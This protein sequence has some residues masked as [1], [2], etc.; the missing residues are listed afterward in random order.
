L[1]ILKKDIARSLPVLLVDGGG[2]VVTGVV[3]GSVTVVT[4]KNGGALTGFTLTNK[5]TELGQ[6]LYTID[7]ADTDL[8]TEGFFA[9]LVTVTGCDQYSGIMYVSDWETNVDSILE[10][11]AEIGTAGASLTDLGGMSTGMKAEVQQEGEDALAAYDPPTRTELTTDKN[12]IIAEVD[13]NEAKIDTIDTVVDGIQTDLSNDTDGLGALKAL[14]DAIDTVVDAIKDVTDQ[15]PDAGALSDLA[16]LATRLSAVRAG[17]LDELASYN[18]PADVDTLKTY[19][20]ILD[21]GTNGLINLKAILDAIQAKTDNLPSDPADQ[22]SLEGT[23]SNMALDIV[24][25]LSEDITD[26]QT[27]L[28]AILTAM[29]GAGWTTETLKAI[30]TAVDANGNDIDDAINN[31]TIMDGK[32]T[33]LGTDL[34]YVKQKESGRWK[35]ENNQLTYYDDDGVTVLKRFNLFNSRGLPTNQN[36][37]ERV[38]V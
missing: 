26:A 7:F 5:W 30:K 24:G 38:P 32:L 14:I 10:D 8:D 29:K 11:T 16:T 9:Y 35:I 12:S 15:L 31:Q 23:I 33:A 36:P 27:A 25:F 34:T 18:L 22:S 2:A 21:N 17:Y 3:E 20:D 28:T 37:Y 6:G 4:S 1:I 19:C 13:A